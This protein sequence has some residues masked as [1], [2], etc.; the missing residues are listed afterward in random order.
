MAMENGKA[1][2]SQRTGPRS[3]SLDGRE[4]A[5]DSRV[6][7]KFWAQSR[8]MKRNCGFAHKGAGG[9]GRKKICIFHKRGCCRFGNKCWNMHEPRRLCAFHQRG[10]CRFGKRCWNVHEPPK[11]EQ[12]AMEQEIEKC[13]QSANKLSL[14]VASCEQQ[15][16]AVLEQVDRLEKESDT[17]SKAIADGKQELE[18]LKQENVRLKAKATESEKG[19]RKQQEGLRD[20]V[21][22]LKQRPTP[23]DLDPGEIVARG[24]CSWVAPLIPKSLD[25]ERARHGWMQEKIRKVVIYQCMRDGKT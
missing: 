4:K 13:K 6:N 7:C 8:C 16:I 11:L 9:S 23:K 17:Q 18:A 10:C 21:E 25:S 24:L 1:S 19:L 20:D 14:G 5:S 3:R 12:H 15:L 22:M 2:K